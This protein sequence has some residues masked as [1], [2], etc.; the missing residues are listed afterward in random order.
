M[1][2]RGAGGR[3]PALSGAVAVAARKPLKRLTLARSARNTPLKRGVNEILGEVDRA[4]MRLGRT[5]LFEPVLLGRQ[6]RDKLLRMKMAAIKS[7]SA[8]LAAASA[9]HP[10][11]FPTDS[12]E[13]A[14][15]KPGS[16]SRRVRAFFRSGAAQPLG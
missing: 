5:G 4:G 3:I 14:G 10:K 13:D 1:F 11:F 16:E 6:F 7:T 15:L 8:F 12:L 2:R 9:P